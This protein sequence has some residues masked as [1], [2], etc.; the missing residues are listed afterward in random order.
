VVRR[1]VAVV[2]AGALLLGP[3]VSLVGVAV[4]MNP[5]AHASCVLAAPGA[6]VSVGDVPDHL[7]VTTRDGVAI[8][9]EHSQLV[10]AATIIDIGARTSVSAATGWSWR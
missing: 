7:D 5:A 10:Q 6:G 9:L 4:L 2:L 8:R 3:G 1:L